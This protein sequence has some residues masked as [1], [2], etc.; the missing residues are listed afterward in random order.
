MVLKRTLVI[1]SEAKQ[2]H[3]DRIASQRIAVIEVCSKRLLRR[4]FL[5]M[6]PGQ[7]PKLFL[8]DFGSA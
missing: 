3:T 8:N 1:V 6:T 4:G 5:A 7:S 2:S